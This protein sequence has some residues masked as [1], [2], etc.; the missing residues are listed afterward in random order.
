MFY[1]AGRKMLGA[2]RARLAVSVVTLRTLALPASGLAADRQ[3]KPPSCHAGRTV[4]HRAGIRAFVIV[5]Q[6]GHQHQEG[7]SYKTFYIC[8]PALRTAHVFDQGAPFTFEDVYDY[9]LFGERLG[10]IYSSRGVQN[11]SAEGIG[12]VNVRS[13]RAKEGAI[14][15]SEDL[16]EGNEEDP[17]LPKVPIDSVDYVIADDGTVA[18]LGEG[19]EPVEWEV[20]LLPVKPRSLGRP[21][22]LF[23]AKQGQ[24]GLEVDSLAITATSVTWR[25]KS[26]QPGSASR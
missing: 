2:R 16:T 21:R 1:R 18:V 17:G 9:K 6:F 12:W 24:E 5:R 23:T 3:P 20:A 26:G 25:T 19:R 22:R 7:S 8:S 11:G 14:H 15:E 4:F 10:F 13:G